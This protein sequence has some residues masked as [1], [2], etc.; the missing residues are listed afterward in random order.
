M[1]ICVVFHLGTPAEWPFYR[2]YL[3]NVPK[4]FD[5]YVTVHDLER[6][7]AE[8]RELGAMGAHRLHPIV[9]PNR[10]MDTG[11]FLLAIRRLRRSYDLL[12][13]VHTKTEKN[14]AN[15]RRELLDP[16][17]AS[18]KAVR[19]VMA[20]FAER[21]V[22]MVGARR[23]LIKEPMNEAVDAYARGL[24]LSRQPG[25]TFIAGTMFW[26]RPSLVLRHFALVD[27]SRAVLEMPPGDE[28]KRVAMSS[29]HAMERIFGNLVT[30]Q[31][32]QIRGL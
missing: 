26:V 18:P 21:R 24:G 5:L 10:G 32:Y 9:V 6:S 27:V 3:L 11:P 13:K 16:I 20:C 29:A 8:L 14:V 2:P 15:W 4:P 28:A 25:N 31:G 7:R 30:Q 12:L 22:G 1:R 19:R 23:W 17:L